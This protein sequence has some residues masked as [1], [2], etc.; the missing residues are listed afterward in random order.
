MIQSIVVTNHL[1][2]SLTLSMGSPSLSGFSVRGIT[3]LV[4]PK[5]SIN[6]T[7]VLTLDGGYYNSS[8]VSYRNIV[9]TLG[10][11]AGVIDNVYYSI[12]DIRLKSYRYFPIKKE[13]ELL[14]TTE[15]RSVIAVGRVESNE[16]T[17]FSKDQTTHISIICPDAYFY[18]SVTEF[19]A[20]TYITPLFK[21]PFSNESTSQKLLNLGAIT[22]QTEKSIVYEGDSE[23]GVLIR[24][25]AIGSVSDLTIYNATSNET[26]FINTTILATLTGNVIIA[27]DDILISTVK[28]SKY[29]YLVRN[30]VA[31]NILPCLANTSTWFQLV[32]G[33]NLFNYSAVSGT[34]NISF[35]IEYDQLYEGI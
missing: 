27:G 4:P 34:N 6:M 11:H 20:F 10:F 12:E 15:N 14:I 26:M 25:H 29:I 22:L 35:S 9:L 32:S 18:D 31:I 13:V 21:F 1:G 33:D 30:G 2:E 23:V 3:G 28:G 17:I 7:E 5:A 19:S 16:P 8:R 24:I